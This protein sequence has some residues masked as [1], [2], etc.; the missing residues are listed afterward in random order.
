[1]T[2]MALATPAAVV[3]LDGQDVAG[4]V[5]AVRVASRFGAPTQ[6]EITLH[7]PAGAWPAGWTGKA[8]SVRI[9]VALFEGDVTAVTLTRDA[10]GDP[11]PR[12]ARVVQHRQSDFDLLVEVA[13]KAGRL[14]AP[15]GDTIALVTLD[16]RGE[17]IALRYGAN[18][19]EV[20]VEANVDRAAASV[21]ADGWDADT[22]ESFTATTRDDA[23]GASVHLLD[24]A[25]TSTGESEAA[26]RLVLDS[27]RAG[28]LTV[29]GT[30]AGDGRIRAG[31]RIVVTGVSPTIEGRFTVAEA[32]HTLDGNGFLTTFDTRPPPLPAA[33]R[34]SVVT[35][36][37][38]TAVDD[39]QGRGRVRV[40]LPAWG[41]VDV[42]WLGV[43][44]PG[45]GAGKGLV[46]L[47]DVGDAVAVALPHAD[48]E[49][50]LVL[51]SL[52]GTVTPPDP[53]IDGA[54]T[55]RF[56]LHTADGQSIVVDDA[57]HSLRLADRT[58]SFVE[59]APGA[60]R[61]SAQTDLV[62]EAPGH[63]VTI[64]AA[65]VDFVNAT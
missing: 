54:A 1:M 38:V 32:V 36:G 35:L 15:D 10:D 39:P 45:A 61:L 13:A 21:T 5:L 34:G 43:V 55:R 29:R 49:A 23:E 59:L 2:G 60:L 30:A 64:R 3:Q 58:G 11:G 63:T 26:A 25:A 17:D 20:T 12:F 22:A 8:L 57:A 37:R 7:D 41:G 9:G 62:L 28:A 53:G 52:Y 33:D 24:R 27:R 19:H 51:G 44:C 4:T 56:S 42:G 6:C 14:V 50:G 48:P 31:A 46:V 47:P 16:G 18:L 40:T 65:T